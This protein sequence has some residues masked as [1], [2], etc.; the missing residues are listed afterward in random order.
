MKPHHGCARRRQ[1]R[2]AVA[3][4]ARL[5]VATL[6]GLA[7]FVAG[8]VGPGAAAAEERPKWELGLG[9]VFFTQPD[10]IGSD[11]YR[12]YP[13]PF[14]WL[15]Y[16]GSRVRIDRE[17]VQTRIFG[18]DLVRLDLSVSGQVS[19]DSSKNNRR[20]DMPDRDWVLQL[21]PTLKFVV[22]RSD[23]GRHSVDVDVPLRVALA[24]DTDNFSYEGLVASPKLVYRYEP[25]G[26]RFEGN[27]GLEFGNNDYNEYYYSVADRYD[28]PSRPA[29]G[30]DGGYAGVRLSAGVSR[31]F[32]P[33]YLGLFTRYFNLEG[34]TF[35]D[36]PLVGS[37][38]AFV[39]G[40]AI[41]WVWMKSDEMVPV[42]A[43]ANLAGRASSA[44]AAPAQVEPVEVEPPAARVPLAADVPP[45]AAPPAV[46]RTPEA[47]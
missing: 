46:E 8:L 30:A 2:S 1:H 14:P 32:G 47:R 9:S 45:A 20:H 33:I 3:S 29:Y 5:R 25:E 39:G 22:A 36:S 13:I 40:I 10:Y 4:P 16:R 26:W 42:G 44:S 28:T 12:F 43:A 18:T 31:Y 19:V 37:R 23:D 35:R 15:I 6:V 17:A 21:G 11:D 24:I 7:C 27:A 41:G 34:A 38:S